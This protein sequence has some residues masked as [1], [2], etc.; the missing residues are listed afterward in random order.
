MKTRLLLSTIGLTCLFAV[1]TGLAAPVAENWENHCQKCHGADGKGQTKA[2]KKLKLK[3]YTD[4]KVQA[5]MTDA[6]I[7]KY[8]NEGAKDD[9]GKE[10]MK[11]FKGELSAEEITDLVAYVRKFKA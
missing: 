11:P 4:A 5:E 1:T 6:D 10:K 9:A 8:I 3:D 2:G 7:V